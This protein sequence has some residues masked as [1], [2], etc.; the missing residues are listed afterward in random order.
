MRKSNI[1]NSLT[2]VAGSLMVFNYIIPFILRLFRFSASSQETYSFI[3]QWQLSKSLGYLSKINFFSHL[4]DLRMRLIHF[5][6]IFNIVGFIGLIL[7]I[8]SFLSMKYENKIFPIL[9]ILISI[10]V[11]IFLNLFLAILCLAGGILRLKKI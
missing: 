4:T 8:L 7:I 2:L 5:D 9:I 11:A 3:T 1:G 6:H 10:F